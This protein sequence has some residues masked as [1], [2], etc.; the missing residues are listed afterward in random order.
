ETGS[1]PQAVAELHD[2]LAVLAERK[3]IVPDVR[4]LD[5]GARFVIA[6]MEQVPYM[7]KVAITAAGNVGLE[8]E[9]N[10]VVGM[11]LGYWEQED[12]VIPDH[13]GVIGLLD[14]AYCSLTTLQ[15]FSDQYKLQTGKHMFPDD[16]SAANRVM[17]QV[18]GDPYVGQLDDFV[19]RAIRES[20]VMDA[21][22]SLASEDKEHFLSANA[23]IW[24]HGPASEMSVE[25]LLALGAE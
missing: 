13:L 11:V 19:T 7:L 24:N 21:V 22:R 20:G 18:I 14:D 2:L 23:N 8:A 10:Q 12:D 3:G 16:L 1:D 5:R 4:D 6:Y 9:M 17:R 25:P 15:T